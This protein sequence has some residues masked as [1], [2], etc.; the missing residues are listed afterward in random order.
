MGDT[1]PPDVTA[2]VPS[3]EDVVKAVATIFGRTVAELLGPDRHAALSW[4]RQVAMYLL[5]TEQGGRHKTK[6]VAQI[7]RRKSHDCALDA[8]TKVLGR[9]AGEGKD[10]ELKGQIAAILQRIRANV[11]DRVSRLPPPP[12][13][14]TLESGGKVSARERKLERR[15]HEL[16][17]NNA[18]LEGRIEALEHVLGTRVAEVT[19]TPRSGRRDKQTKALG[20]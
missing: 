18:K 9:L 10:G 2:H 6:E 3:T 13:S 1:G 17:L 12:L 4:A 20:Q 11:A 5:L 16:E 8:Q 7:F 14:P 19:G 15:V